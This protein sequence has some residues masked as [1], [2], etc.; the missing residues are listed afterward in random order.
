MNSLVLFMGIFVLGVFISSVAQI[1]LKKSAEKE[2]PN[3]IREYL[4]VRVIVGYAI[5]FAATLCSV[6]AYKVVPLSYGP[7]LE[8]TGYIFVA[9]LSWLF[10]K[11]KISLQKG[12]GIMVII[13]GI[14]IYSIKI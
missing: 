5:F 8:S 14:V 4:N 13:V 9:V 10:I 12:I 7:I 6:Y 11:E 2:Y 1:L 3:K